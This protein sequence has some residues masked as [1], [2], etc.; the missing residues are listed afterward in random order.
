MES[1][2]ALHET[3][4]KCV[5]SFGFKHS[6]T[7]TPKKRA[8][9]HAFGLARTPRPAVPNL[10]RVRRARTSSS[11]RILLNKVVSESPWHARRL[12][13]A[14][15]VARKSPSET[16]NL[17]RISPDDSDAVTSPDEG[18]VKIKRKKGKGR[19][20]R[21]QKKVTLEDINAKVCHKRT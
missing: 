20:K 6:L 4:K 16:K 18:R 19:R 1:Y 3:E 5:D 11:S 2:A 15:V 10:S 12:F 21:E 7:R 13:P 17:P 14:R 8:R 9:I